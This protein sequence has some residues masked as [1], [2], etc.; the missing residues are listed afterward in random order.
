MEE[1]FGKAGASGFCVGTAFFPAKKGKV[2]KKDVKNVDFELSRLQT[3]VGKMRMRLFSAKSVSDADTD[4]IIDAEISILTDP[5]F[6]DRVEMRIINEAV[7][8]EYAVW[9]EGESFAN[10]LSR[11]NDEYMRERAVDVRGVTERL[12]YDL[13]GDAWREDIPKGSIVVAEELTPEYIVSM[14]RDNVVGLVSKKGSRTSHVT[15]LCEGYKLPYIYDV[16]F[17]GKFEAGTELLI[18]AREGKLMVSPDSEAKLSIEKM[19][20]EKEDTLASLDTGNVKICANISRA[21]EAKD[22][23]LAGADGIG[24]FRTEFLFMGEA[25]P[26]EDEQFDV[27]KEVLLTMGEKKTVIRTM[28]LGEDKIPFCPE[29]KMMCESTGHRGIRLCLENPNLFRTQ[30]RALF[31]AAC[32][33][34]LNIMYPMIMDI[35]EVYEI[36]KQVKI[37]SSELEARGERYKVPKQGIMIETASAVSQSLALARYADFFSIG[38]NDLFMYLYGGG[39]AFRDEVIEDSDDLTG[40]MEEAIR[41]VTESAHRCNIPVSVCGELAG[42]PAAI[43]KLISLGIDELSMAPAKI[44]GRSK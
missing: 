32:F 29:L 9:V 25:L 36:K 31:R 44:T 12:A 23:L 15:I 34:N 38:T 17:E 41:T 37:A 16:D 30:L 21:S 11:L 14:N 8:A 10:E 18:N 19:M 7:N 39:R 2:E 27:Y 3:T 42:D 35:T 5:A 1:L 28:D 13:R 6:L 43:P 33:G 40:K 4:E 22:A 20:S 26:S 24:L